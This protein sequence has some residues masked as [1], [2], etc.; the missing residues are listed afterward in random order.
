MVEAREVSGRLGRVSRSL[1]MGGESTPDGVRVTRVAAMALLHDALEE[2]QLVALVGEMGVGRR[3]LVE[4]E[5]SSRSDHGGIALRADLGGLSAD[6]AATIVAGLV[7]GCEDGVAQGSAVT[8]G[9]MEMPFLEGPPLETVASVLRRLE[10]CGVSIMVTMHPEGETLVEE[11]PGCV[12]LHAEDLVVGRHELRSWGP[13]FVDV[14][15]RWL[16]QASHGIASL[17]AA[18]RDSDEPLGP[19]APLE[20]EPWRTALRRLTEDALRP[21]LMEEERSLRAAMLVLGSG[22]FE[23][24]SGLGLRVEADVVC[25]IARDAPLFGIDVERGTFSCVT[26]PAEETGRIVR[27]FATD[28]PKVLRAEVDLLMQ[29]G[30]FCQGAG[31]ASSCLPSEELPGLVAEWPMELVDA[32]FVTLVRKG[33]Q[34]GAEGDLGLAVAQV[35]CDALVSERRDCSRSW[36]CVHAAFGGTDADGAQASGP[37]VREG[38]S[39]EATMALQAELMGAVRRIGHRADARGAGCPALDL[40]LERARASEDGIVRGLALHLR[41]ARELM[42]GNPADAYAELAGSWESRDGS[43][44]TAML[45]CCDYELASALMGRAA[46]PLDLSSSVRCARLLERR[47]LCDLRA[48]RGLVRDACSLLSGR[49][50]DVEGAQRGLSRAS[51]RKD[52]VIQACILVVQGYAAAC[53]GLWANAHVYVMRAQR[54]ALRAGAG[55]LWSVASLVDALSQGNLGEWAAAQDLSPAFERVGSARA[56]DLLARLVRAVGAGRESEAE[57]VSARLGSQPCTAVLRPLLLLVAGGDDKVSRG[58][59]ATLGIPWAKALEQAR[60]TRVP[61]A[62]GQ[63]DVSM[64]AAREPGPVPR[65][66]S[67]GPSRVVEE[68]RI[69]LL[70]DYVVQAGPRTLLSGSWQRRSAGLL[71]ALLA[72]ERG[73]IMPR[74]RII[75]II[76]PG[77]DLM[78]GKDRLYTAAASARTALGG[79][80]CRFIE[81]LQGS[82]SLNPERVSCDVDAF[83]ELVRSLASSGPSDVEVVERCHEVQSLYRGDLYVPPGVGSGFFTSRRNELR[84]RYVDAMVLGVEAAERLGRHAEALW[85]ADEAWPGSEGREDMA[86]SYMRALA[87]TGRACEVGTVYEQHSL[88]V[89]TDVGRPPSPRMRS[90]VAQLLSKGQR[91]EDA[92][93]YTVDLALGGLVPQS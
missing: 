81:S 29:D 27:P 48:Y 87:A 11:L 51:R 64:G 12:S 13:R 23:Q 84:K 78:V 33:A 73:H 21:G 50:L 1:R 55:Y 39:R 92:G 75:S 2:S 16:L 10:R 28:H 61:E 26:L 53:E 41:V 85:F 5:L 63:P 31:I 91:P 58:V 93:G 4:A 42:D 72:T 77:I 82:L 49:A 20:G 7:P 24:V 18:L 83:E 86:M 67:D 45:L 15:H 54:C 80:G 62:V 32:G 37:I 79:K 47:G 34:D 9:L 74:H 66:P 14:P 38:S 56:V 88:R 35:A 40:V 76:W 36:S 19:G 68:A 70:G 3:G 22:T 6:E 89:I 65:V 59:A 69:R 43:T 17:V 44:L 30:R 46:S 90:F 8:L 25:G 52:T 60:S 57:R 71:V